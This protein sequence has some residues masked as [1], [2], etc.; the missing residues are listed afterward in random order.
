MEKKLGH[1]FFFFF[2][3]SNSTFLEMKGFILFYFDFDFN[4]K[5]LGHKFFLFFSNST[6]MKGFFF[7]FSYRYW[8]KT[9]N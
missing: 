9:K 7:F 5:K 4:G 3:P 1:K 8:N 6:F 2:F